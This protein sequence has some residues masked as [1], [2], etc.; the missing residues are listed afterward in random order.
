MKEINFFS[1]IP[2]DSNIAEIGRGFAVAIG[3]MGLLRL[4]TT[5]YSA[6]KGRSLPDENVL[7]PFAGVGRR[8][9]SKI[10]RWKKVNTTIDLEAGGSDHK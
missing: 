6:Q 10:P 9:L 2:E 5:D 7:S 1:R 3:V 4:A 8:I